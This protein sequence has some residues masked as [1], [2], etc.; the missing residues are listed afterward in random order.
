MPRY[1]TRKRFVSLLEKNAIEK[2]PDSDGRALK[3]AL[4]VIPKK[5]GGGG[6]IGPL[7]L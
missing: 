3:S 7:L 2:A 4:F 6:A 1:A 5:A